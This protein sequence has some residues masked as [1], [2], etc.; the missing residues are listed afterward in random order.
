MRSYHVHAGSA[1]HELAVDELA[2]D[3]LAVD[4]VLGWHVWYMN[5]KQ[6]KSFYMIL[7]YG[8]A[9]NKLAVDELAVDELAVDKLLRSYMSVCSH[10]CHSSNMFLSMSQTG[11][12]S[13]KSRSID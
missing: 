4:K 6:Y 11:S 8:L 1:F 9:V 12:L 2:V 3:E 13:T 7:L 5:V 10:A